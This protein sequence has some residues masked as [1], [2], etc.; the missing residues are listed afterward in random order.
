MVLAFETPWY[1]DSLG[2][3]IIEDQV[4]ITEAG[5]EIMAQ[6]SRNLTSI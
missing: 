4:L 2:G 3:S 1:I 5:A 6:S